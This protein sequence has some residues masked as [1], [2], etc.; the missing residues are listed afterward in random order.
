P[1][2]YVKIRKNIDICNYLPIY[3][4]AICRGWWTFSVPSLGEGRVGEGLLCLGNSVGVA[5]SR[6]RY[7]RQ[8]D[9][10]LFF[11]GYYQIEYNA[12]G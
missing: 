9:G 10:L 1:L 5:F 6:R 8:D 7:P 12:F 4:P 11:D 3:Y 2:F